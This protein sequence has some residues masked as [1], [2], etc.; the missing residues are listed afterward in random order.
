MEF[1]VVP[2]KSDIKIKIEKGFLEVR[3]RC[4]KSISKPVL[5]ITLKTT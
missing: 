5:R 3:G 2:P 4:S 1:F